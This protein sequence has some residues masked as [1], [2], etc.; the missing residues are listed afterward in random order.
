MN[1][2]KRSA[3]KKAHMDLLSNAIADAKLVKEVSVENA[4]ISLKEAFQPKLQRVLS[5]QLEADEPTEDP[6]EDG[7]DTEAP[8]DMGA[9]DGGMDMSMGDSDADDFGG[10]GD[11]DGDDIQE[12]DDDEIPTDD[13]GDDSEAPID[14]QPVADAGA[15]DFGGGEEDEEPASDDLDLESIIRE[16]ENS[17]D[18][19]DEEE[20][21]EI[22]EDADTSNIGNGD[23]V[24]PSTASN[25]DSTEDP[26]KGTL[27]EEDEPTDED[28]TDMSLEEI[29]SALREGDDDEMDATAEVA[30]EEPVATEVPSGDG[31]SEEAEEEIQELTQK[32]AEAYAVIK[33][34][35]G[36]LNETN[37][38]NAKLLYSTKLF[39]AYALDKKQKMH[40]LEAFDRVTTDREAKLVFTTLV[41][42][43][44]STKAQTVKST[45]KETY[46]RT[47]SKTVKSTKPTNKNILDEGFVLKNRWQ[48]M[49]GIKK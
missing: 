19:G 45:L 46:A 49:A 16:L 31:G 20:G 36:Q 26:G 17:L 12:G 48:E 10:E 29:L 18:G 39:N 30:P 23:N 38:L 32:L 5:H 6:I 42:T 11:E 3:S 21:E 44:R 7:D 1:K 41:E 40:V 47:S 8:T 25:D 15:T 27:I 33:Y 13:G 37:L 4:K 24:Q 9:E 2:N 43:L 28:S 35:R 34:I 22:Q 14:D